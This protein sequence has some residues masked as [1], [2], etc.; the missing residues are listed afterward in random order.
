[1]HASSP[2]AV[3]NHEHAYHVKFKPGDGRQSESTVHTAQQTHML[4]ES[5]ETG[6]VRCVGPV[7][8]AATRQT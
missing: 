1:M 3:P 8:V 2:G 4:L 5:L 6:Q 7:I